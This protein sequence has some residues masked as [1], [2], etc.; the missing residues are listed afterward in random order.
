MKKKYSKRAKEKKGKDGLV[1]DKKGWAV[2]KFISWYQAKR[3]K[4]KPS[5][6]TFGDKTASSRFKKKRNL[7]TRVCSSCIIF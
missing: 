1:C 3:E 7:H 5:R 6:Y 2:E 4:D